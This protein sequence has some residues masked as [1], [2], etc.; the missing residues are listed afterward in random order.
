MKPSGENLLVSVKGIYD[1]EGRSQESA[2]HARQIVWVDLGITP[3]PWIFCGEGEEDDG[4][5][6]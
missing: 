5:S 2:P 3:E 4:S 1:E 6:R